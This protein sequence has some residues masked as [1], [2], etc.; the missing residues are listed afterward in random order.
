MIE[1]PDRE[2]LVLAVQQV[3]YDYA[4][5]FL[6]DEDVTLAERIVDAVVL[7]A[8]RTVA[9]DAA[10]RVTTNQVTGSVTGSVVQAHTIT[11]GIP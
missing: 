10:R 1:L 6:D 4:H 7:P 5:R 2:S 9:A 8:L 3:R 11:G